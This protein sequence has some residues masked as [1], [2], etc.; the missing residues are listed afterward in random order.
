MA[1]LE[2]YVAE[3]P[4]L[5]E[6]E[7]GGVRVRGTRVSLDSVIHAYNSGA[8][9]EDIIRSFTTLKLRDVY[10]VIT[11]YLDYKDVVEAYIARRQEE[12]DEIRRKFEALY[13]LGQSLQAKMAA[14]KAEAERQ[15]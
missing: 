4:P 6:T 1:L 14:R 9:P 10:A 12:A 13:P 8:T 3:P 15:P 2:S 5:D 11:Y 7:Q